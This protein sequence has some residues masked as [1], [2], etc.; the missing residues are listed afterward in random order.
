ARAADRWL[1]EHSEVRVLRVAADSGAILDGGADR[2]PVAPL[3]LPEVGGDDPA[4]LFFTSG[5]TA[6]PKAVLGT[7]AGLSHFLAWQRQE[8]AVG[9]EDR[10]AQLTGLS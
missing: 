9:P 1:L 4:Y 7:Q 10:S 2:A 6:T 8:F 3:P 5:T